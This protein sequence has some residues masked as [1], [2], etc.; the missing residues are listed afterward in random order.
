[1][2]GSLCRDSN[3]SQALVL[4]STGPPLDTAR[5]ILSPHRRAFAPAHLLPSVFH[6]HHAFTVLH[7]Q[8][9]AQSSLFTDGHASG[10]CNQATSLVLLTLQAPSP[11]SSPRHDIRCRNSRLT[12]ISTTRRQAPQ[13]WGHL[14]S[15]WCPQLSERLL[16]HRTHSATICGL[17]EQL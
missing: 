12:A 16:A 3:S 15:P 13:V 7:Y 11:H 4:C 14:F 17:N 5:P 9:A 10:I 2:W 1:M 6:P 8:M